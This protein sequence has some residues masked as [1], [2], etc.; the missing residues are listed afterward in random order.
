MGSRDD[1]ERLIAAKREAGDNN[2][3]E[4]AL[5]LNELGQLKL[6][7]GDT[8]GAAVDFMEVR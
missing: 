8:A 1:L 5:L 3:P 7:E 4:F 6:A 2:S